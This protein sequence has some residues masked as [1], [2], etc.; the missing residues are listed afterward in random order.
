MTTFSSS[1]SEKTRTRPCRVRKLLSTFLPPFNLYIMRMS[2]RTLL[3]PW[4]LLSSRMTHG[5]ARCCAHHHSSSLLTDRRT[6]F[7]FF[8]FFRVRKLV[9]L[10]Q[11]STFLFTNSPFYSRPPF[12]NHARL[13]AKSP[14]R[15]QS[16][17]L[18]IE[19]IARA[20]KQRSRFFGIR[21]GRQWRVR[22]FEAIGPV[23]SGHSYTAVLKKVCGEVSPEIGKHVLPRSSK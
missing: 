16:C 14:R 12:V 20:Q 5:D 3:F 6:F 17:R 18:E 7:L 1:S 2:E 13:N 22:N 15:A 10:R 8:Y 11:N 21:H 9:L 23:L 4:Q 19:T